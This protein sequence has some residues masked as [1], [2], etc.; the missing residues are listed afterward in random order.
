MPTSIT[1][2]L[3]HR[4]LR[5]RNTPTEY[6]AIT[7]GCREWAAEYA[8]NLGD[9]GRELPVYIWTLRCVLGD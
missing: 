1:L 7:T 3:L 4:R 9:R 8:Q 6:A 5:R 2:Y